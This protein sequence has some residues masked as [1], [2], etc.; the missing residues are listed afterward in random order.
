MI[1]RAVI[2][3]VSLWLFAGLAQA[4]MLPGAAVEAAPPAKL[5][6]LELL[7]SLGWVLIP[8]S[9]LSFVVVLL[10]FIN[11]F[12]L[13]RGNVVNDKF[14]SRARYFIKRN[15]LDG[16]L[17]LCEERGDATSRVLGK[18]LLFAK[19]EPQIGLASLREIG[20]AEGNRA[21]IEISRW[22]T[23]LMDMG[24][25]GPLL[26][27]LGTVLGILEAFGNLASDVTPMRTVLLAGGVSRALVATFV[28]L[29]IG[30]SAMGM[31]AFFRM[32]VQRLVSLLES[33]V[34][35]LIVLCS[36]YLR[37]GLGVQD[38]GDDDIA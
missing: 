33:S 3:M 8:L 16:A 7:K 13:H 38:T 31:Y 30:L 14:M 10:I 15:D 35:E 1:Q 5:T 9:L 21:A 34:T 4:Q 2:T 19:R 26:G 32:Q 23:L 6:L 29:C 11:L 36:E 22:N 17:D 18:V 24:V 37:T 12:I 25:L 27:L 20:E 28:G